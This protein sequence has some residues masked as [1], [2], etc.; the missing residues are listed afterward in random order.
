MPAILFGSISTLA[1]T[2]ELQRQA[3]NDAFAAHDLDWTWD[4][5]QYR[6]MLEHS[7]GRDRVAAYASSRGQDVDAAAV[8]RT[9]TELFQQH[10][11]TA[12]LS[13]RPGVLE[14][15]R[16]ARSS[17]V[18]VGLVTTT[19]P[20][21]VEALLSALTP[22]V[23]EADFAVVVDASDVDD[24]KPAAD[25]YLHALAQLAVT[26]NRAVVIEDNAG[27]VQA[28]VT[29]GLTCVAF[30]NENT[31]AHAFP[32]AERTVD[33]LDPEVLQHLASR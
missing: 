10:L 6:A 32:G 7:G 17:G 14:T 2:S 3:F 8:H 33:H 5:E 23:T 24:P 13:P 31:A 30:P 25:A 1:D 4:R 9:K 11:A 22:Q 19:A 29:A 21:N 26:A 27:G 12:D 15:L 18:D 20:E 16:A 28:A